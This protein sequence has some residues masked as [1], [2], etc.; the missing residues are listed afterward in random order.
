MTIMTSAQFRSVTEPVLNKVFDGLYDKA[1]EEWKNIFKQEDA[2]ERRWE[3]EP[4]LAG[5]GIAQEKGEGEPVAYDFGGQAWVQKFV[6]KVY[7]LAFSLSEEALEDGLHI[8]LGKLYT[9][10]LVR[11]MI[12]AREV[13]HANVLNRALS[14]SYLGG[15][16]K[17]LLASDHP[18]YDGASWSNRLSTPANVSE[19][20]IEQA[21]A[22]IATAKDER[23]KFIPIKAT[24]LIVHPNQMASAVRV[25]ESTLRSGTNTN[26]LNVIAA[27]GWVPEIVELRRLTNDKFWALQTDAPRGLISKERAKMSRKMEGDFDSGSMRYKARMRFDCSWVDPRCLYGSEGV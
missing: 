22:M 14:T 23:G 24:R 25:V 8:N 16:G 27:K 26:D 17:P 21:R 9:E 10:H 13:A 15:D 5:F 20:A 7:S 12:E 11:A 3:E 2:Q 6:H 19:A 4:M 1:E 18:R